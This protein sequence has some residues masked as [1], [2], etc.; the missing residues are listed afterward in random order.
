MIDPCA[1]RQLQSR[2]G[3]PGALRFEAGPNALIR[4]IVATPQAEAEIYLHGAHVTQYRPR[5]GRPVLFMSAHSRFE[6]GTPI[7]GG[8]PIV[9]PW[10]GPRAGD[11]S[12]PM[13]G[14]AR[15]VEWRMESATQAS[16]GSV[17]IVLGLDAA[18]ATHPAWPHAYILQYRIGVGSTLELALE[19]RNAT[20]RT[21]IFEEAFHTYLAVSDVRQVS[22]VGLAGTQYLDKTDGMRRKSQGAEPIRITGETDRVYLNTKATCVVDDPGGGCRLLVE[23]GGSDVTVVWNPWIAKAHAMPDFGD[24]EWPQMLCLETGNAAD[25]AI[26]LAPGHRHEMR[27]VI[28]SSSR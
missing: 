3:I 4:A 22:I 5:G 1:S 7:R 9:F 23:K 14:F 20:P 12:A 15:S 19:V 6:P 8:V 16:D 18:N 25:H 13:H 26:S 17:T 27:A 28:R 10:F 24:D 2:Y 21:I 11:P